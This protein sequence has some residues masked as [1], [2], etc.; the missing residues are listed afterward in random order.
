MLKPLP[1]G[2][3][4]SLAAAA[5][6]LLAQ[7]LRTGAATWNWN[8]NTTGDWSSSASWQGGAIPP[9]NDLTTILNFAGNV[10]SAATPTTY[11]ANNDFAGTF[12]LNQLILNGIDASPS[13]SGI[14]N[15]I[16][17]NPLY[18]GGT[19]PAVTMSGS[20]SFAVNTPV[21]IA[22]GLTVGGNGFGTVTFNAKVSGFADITKLGS[23][24]MRFGTSPV[25]P[26]TAAP[27]ENAWSGRLLINAGTVRFNNNAQAGATAIRANPVVFTGG[28]SLTIKRD[29]GDE[30]AG[31]ETSLR[32]GTLSGNSGFVTATV[33]GANTS[34]Y[35]IVITTLGSG[36]FGGS[37]TMP[38]PTGTGDDPGAFIV[39]GN[40]SQ[41]LTGPLFIQKDVIVGDGATLTL[42]GSARLS[43]QTKGAVVFAGG[44]LILDNTAG[45]V[46]FGRLRDGSADSSTVEAVGGGT[47]TLIGNA[48]NGT[49]E[50]TGRLQIGSGS[51]PRSGH[52]TLSIVHNSATAATELIFQDY[53]RNQTAV[54][55]FAT[56][57]FT[58]TN[59]AGTVLTLGQSGSNPRF[60][61]ITG[62][63]LINSLMSTTAGASSVGWATVNGKDF[64]SYDTT[65]G[66]IA[67]T[68]AP[69]TTTLLPSAN[70]L[71]TA[72]ASTP[73]TSAPYAVNSIKI[74]PTAV[75]QKLNIAGAGNL[76]T[77]A[78]LLVG[79]IDFLISSTSSGGIAGGAPRFF[80]VES[81]V[82]TVDAPLAEPAQPVVKTGKGTLV[83]NNS[84]NATVTATTSINKGVLRAQT[85]AS[86]PAGELRFR[87]GVLEIGGG[88]TFSRSVNFGPGSVNWSG[89]VSD[90]LGGGTPVDDDRGSGGFAAFGADA[91]VDLN[92]PGADLIRWEDNGFVRSSYSLIFGS[93][94]ATHRITWVDSLSLT[95]TAANPANVNYNAREI[96]VI[97]NPATTGDW[98]RITGSISGS[99][100]NDLIKTGN[101][102]LELAGTNTYPGATFIQEGTLLITG[103]S[104]ASF[105][106]EVKSGAT[107]GGNGSIGTVRVGAGGELSPGMPAAFASI[108][109]TGDLAFLDPT[110]KLTI[111]I[112]GTNAGGDVLDAYDQLIVNGSVILDG[113]ELGGSLLNGYNPTTND[114]FFII[115]NDGVDPVQG[116][117]ASGAQ[118]IIGGKIFEI[119]YSANYDTFSL[120][121]GNDVALQ[122]IPE[123]ASALLLAL[124]ALICTRRRRA[125]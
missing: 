19:S 115:L 63:P 40:G 34:N 11:A 105:V 31:F 123:P 69:W 110:A 15:T 48:A 54:Q 59:G 118:V 37:I 8:N 64:A 47:L 2:R 71:V 124:G 89:I 72:D 21:Q 60:R 73:A 74:A 32:I 94:T 107:L 97:D 6:A 121:G 24:T 78:I 102:T 10:G 45:N 82:L 91:S 1:F 86:L 44:N 75:G 84:A 103:S 3:L 101:G 80:N 62:S 29:N 57:D 58:A 7:P 92:A 99:A 108:L 114:R 81:A 104:T 98:A 113:A 79:G 77:T 65:N 46:P 33:E 106:H 53:S 61:F 28:G 76:A 116:Q 30:V 42:G 16:I 35:D 26:A 52:L 51:N 119:Y 38:G 70:A 5:L 83:L 96:R 100:Q 25:F 117:F 112:G 68:T 49:S 88:A 17:G 66:V 39:R 14:F 56:V 120:T 36:T 93:P 109:R 12:Q 125:V 41:T 95:A 22:G 43:G 85:A 122:L 18:F 9:A 20:A 23:S 27:S 67:T 87:G 13:S 111:G 50:T 4:A 55:Q 90:G